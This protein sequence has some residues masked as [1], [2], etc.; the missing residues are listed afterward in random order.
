MHGLC[1]GDVQAVVWLAAVH[2]VRGGDLVGCCGGRGREHVLAL[3]SQQQ[4]C[5]RRWRG[6]PVHLQRRLH[7]VGR[8]NLHSVLGWLLQGNDGIGR[9]Q[10]VR[11][12]H[13]LSLDWGICL[14]DVPD[15]Q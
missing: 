6:E 3:Q 7:W 13:L 5:G 8:R 10:L 11:C 15:Q 2:A 9:L 14:H 1:R 4:L 12:G